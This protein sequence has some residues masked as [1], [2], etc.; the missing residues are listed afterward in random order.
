M[1]Q[2]TAFALFVTG[3]VVI[4]ALF[5]GW[6]VWQARRSTT[7]DLSAVLEINA[8]GVGHMEQYEYEKAESEFRR[9]IQLAPK[10]TPG[11]INLGIALLNQDKEPQL[12][13]A[14]DLFRKVLANEPDN[15]YANFCLG[16]ILAYYRNYTEAIPHFRK[17]VEK[18]PH[19]AGAWYQLGYVLS[20]QGDDPDE[21]TRCF[22]KAHRLNPYMSGP[23]SNLISRIDDEERKQRLVQEDSELRAAHVMAPNTLKYTEQ[24]SRYARV[25]AGTQTP[26]SP[27]PPLSFAALSNFQVQL[28][29]GTRW[30]TPDDL[31]H[32]ELGELRRITRQTFGATLIAWDYNRDN[33]LDLFLV[34][35]VT[36]DGKVGDLLLR[37]DGQGRLTDVTEAA[38][39]SAERPSLGAVSVDFDNNGW[40]DLLLAGA[41][42]T[43]LFR[44]MGKDRFEDVSAAA[45]LDS[46]T[47]VCLG[48]AWLDLDQDGDLDLIL[49][50]FA[51]SPAEAVEALSGRS[52]TG[53]GLAVFVNTGVADPVPAGAFY[54]GLSVKFRRAPD[55]EKVW[56]VSHRPI[57]AVVSDVD[58]D[59]DID[60]IVFV[61]QGPAQLL[62]NQRLLRWKRHEL[63]SPGPTPGANWGL[64][65]D[66]DQ[67]GRNDLFRVASS[68]PS[69]LVWNRSL[70][71]EDPARSFE[72]G[73][74]FD[75]LRQART[76]DMDLDGWPDVIT[77]SS[78]GRIRILRNQ[79]N[80]TLQAES[81]DLESKN[82]PS[83]VQAVL[84]L[85]L[86]GDQFP[87]LLVWQAES[88]LSAWSTK[89]I[90]NHQGLLVRLVGRRENA[91]PPGERVNSD[92][93]GAQVMV[94]VGAHATR[95]EHVPQVGGLGQ[96][97]GPITFGLGPARVNDAIVRLTW[98][99]MVVQAEFLTD[100]KGPNCSLETENVWEVREKNRKPTSCPIVL[101]WDGSKWVYLT[102]FLGAG[103]V[104]E[105]RSG[106]GTRPARPEE[107]LKIP[108]NHLGLKDGAYLLRIAEPMDEIALLDRL[109]LTVIDL[110]PGVDV[111]P[112]ERFATSPPEPTQRLQFFKKRLPVVHARDEKGQDV[113]S[114]LQR[115]DGQMLGGFA[116]R[117]WIGFAADHWVEFDLPPSF[118]S[119]KTDQPMILV[120]SGWT[121]YAFP[122]SIFAA[123][124]AGVGMQPPILEGLTADGRWEP[125][126]EIGFPAGLPRTITCDVTGRLTPDHRR[127]RIRTNMHVYWDEIFVA[128]LVAVK[129]RVH[130]LEVSRAD[131]SY[132]GILKELRQG[133]GPLIAYD[134]IQIEK[135]AMTRWRG[136]LTRYGN[137]T[138]LLQKTDDRL[139][140]IAP[141]DEILVRF[142]AAHL[143]DPPAGWSRQFVLRTWGWCKDASPFTMTGGSVKP[144]PFRSM[145]QYPPPPGE[146][147]PH[148]DDVKRWHTRPMR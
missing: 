42:R 11:Y 95:I 47:D 6:N 133:K 14:I 64:P 120:L 134:P 10:W 35:A 74:T 127:W 18:D 109:Q 116:L 98:P 101:T 69:Q 61:H 15:P 136:L 142:D 4:V 123:E 129:A 17:V 104:G 44:N 94:Q 102:D 3:L 89:A 31:G 124:Q 49:C 65:I 2:R 38:G 77:L 37:N 119:L 72:S 23:L 71:G 137:V 41:G 33:R 19:D 21:A 147:Y 8:R 34:G 12:N 145:S 126:L 26:K 30:A 118:R 115:C 106:G 132:Y 111:L 105:M 5:V 50:R 144:L 55:L 76:A 87:D 114:L 108:S 70:P 96:S 46:I 51:A 75:N 93:L 52:P 73:P 117:S 88:G 81:P 58:G 57:S 139:V 100:P 97:I 62:E 56:T 66:V 9:V 99:D 25:I 135:T 107:S 83:P 148:P 128:P 138:E 1:S 103:S 7:E 79:R 121:D 125:V 86:N 82:S 92:A 27:L 131:L 68:S 59:L 110:P 90:E 39:L 54:G 63:I 60:V 24:S 36:R 140:L 122:E 91:S 48:A 16:F 28:A 32:G 43:Y 85:D 143:P 80:A 40:P 13:E 53:G 112:D 29:P 130:D 22:E 141:G 45:G 67:D 146:E 78:E 113:T 84:P 20:Q